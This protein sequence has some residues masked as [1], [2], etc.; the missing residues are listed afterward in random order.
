MYMQLNREINRWI[1]KLGIDR[2]D[3]QRDIGMGRWIDRQGMDIQIGRSR[4]RQ[5][6]R[7]ID[8]WV[9]KLTRMDGQ[10]ERKMDRPPNQGWAEQESLFFICFL[11]NK[12]QQF[13][14]MKYLSYVG[15]FYIGVRVKERA[16]N[17]CGQL[18]LTFS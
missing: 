11:A 8:G 6:D 10:T 2:P 4:D 15:T 9:D 5:M 14:N 17:V 3:G 16:Y 7:E 12:G 1:D 13:M 18:L